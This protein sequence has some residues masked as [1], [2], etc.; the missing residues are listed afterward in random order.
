MGHGSH[1]AFGMGRRP[2]TGDANR[3]SRARRPACGYSL[4]LSR[5][6]WRVRDNYSSTRFQNPAQTLHNH[7]RSGEIVPEKAMVKQFK[8]HYAGFGCC[9]LLLL[10]SS[11]IYAQE[12]LELDT[13]V[14]TA[15]LQPLSARDVAS[16][17]TVV[18]R[19]EIELK[20]YRYLSDLLR[21]VPGFSVSQ[22]GGAGSQTQVRVRGAEANHL[23]VLMDGVRANDPAGN[24]EFQ[25]Q[26]ALTSNIERVEIIRGPQ[27]A[28]WGSDAIAGVI[29]IIRNK[30][31]NGSY[32]SGN[33]QGGSFNTRD[34]SLEAGYAGDLFR[35]DAWL[36]YLDTDGTNLSRDGN[37]TDGMDNTTGNIALGFDTGDA[38]SGRLSAQLTDSSSEYDDIDYLSTGLPIDA[39][40]STESKQSFLSGQLNYAPP[41][42]AWSG[43]FSIHRMES[44]NNSF[45]NGY[46]TESSAAETLEFRLRGGMELGQKPGNLINFALEREQVDFAQRGAATPWGDPNQD[47]SYHTNGYALEYVGRP[48]E[49]LSWT[50]SARH[51]DYS[52][53]EDASTWQLAAAFEVSPALRLRASVG[54]GSKTPTFTERFG[55]FADLFSGNPELEPESSTAWEIGLDL[56]WAKQRQ[57]L[58]LAYFDQDLQ[59][60]ID[61]FVYDPGIFMFTARNKQSNSHRKGVEAI[62]D[63]KLGKSLTV[64]ASYTYTDASEKDSNGRTVSEARRPKHVA[65]VFAAWYF[66]PDR[67]SISLDLDYAGTQQDVYFSPLTYVSERVEMDAYLVAD[68]AI[69]W[70]L[71]PSL[72]LTGRVSNLLDEQYEEILGFVRPGRAVYAGLR[73]SFDF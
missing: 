70:R 29:N 15:G 30:S 34:A 72:E 42:H 2:V 33:I 65:G 73:G 62:L 25:Y 3:S 64:G 60:E 1:C 71:T 37:E 63:L 13:L 51:D 50:M 41:Q 43:S 40:R 9:A 24:D 58:Q 26:L 4:V 68:L 52:D 67:G 35:V 49:G 23:L 22:A 14:V 54:T 59:D 45:S 38:L 66:T 17:I 32:V 16:S 19:E 7:A 5:R 10:A 39:D 48:F 12:A 36:S 18:S 53:F 28:T 44:D 46:W 6:A 20:Q 8:T 55:Y 27:S 31:N 21:D 11:P 56:A 47:Q 61:G 69:A 57:S